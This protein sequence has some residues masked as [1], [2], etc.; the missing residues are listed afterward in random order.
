MHAFLREMAE[1]ARVLWQIEQ[2][3]QSCGIHADEETIIHYP[4][5]G[6]GVRHFA[7]RGNVTLEWV[8][9]HHDEDMRSLTVKVSIESPDGHR[10]PH[11]HFNLD[12]DLGGQKWF[13]STE[14]DLARVWGPDIEDDLSESDALAIVQK[15]AEWF[16]RLGRSTL[17]N[18]AIALLL[19][20]ARHDPS[21]ITLAH[22][23]ISTFFTRDRL[24]LAHVLFRICSAPAVVFFV[25]RKI[26]CLFCL[27]IYSSSLRPYSPSYRP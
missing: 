27:L 24:A 10:G 5:G 2:I 3:L 26:I 6:V 13:R 17:A 18:N 7:K 11:Q 20:E 4:S 21:Y 15:I 16:S 9:D 14:G 8:A 1:G 19:Q 22:V 12:Y 23:Q 25:L